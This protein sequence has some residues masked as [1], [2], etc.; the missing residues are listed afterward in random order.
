MEQENKIQEDNLQ[1]EKKLN[2]GFFIDTF[3][4]MVD[5]VIVVVDNYARILSQFANVTVF[6][7]KGRKKYDDTKLP[8][9]VVRC[10]AVRLV[11]LD[12]DLPLPKLSHKFKRELNQANLDIV[13]IHSPFTIGNLGVQYAKKHNIPVI[14]TMHSQYKKDFLKETH[15]NNWL[16]NKL[17][18]KCMKIFN[19]C[20]ECWAVND[21]VGEIYY[22]EYGAKKMPKTRF[23]GADLKPFVDEKE[24]Y[25]LKKE[26]DIHDDERV[27]LFVGRITVLKN[28]P[29]ILQSL[30]CLKDSNF[31]FKMFF[32]GAG[33]DM[34][35][36]QK[37]TNAL[38][39]DDLVRFLGRITDREEMEKMYCMADLFLF[40]SLY[41]CNSLVQIEA[42]SQS[43][44]TLFLEGAATADTVTPDKN[45]YVAENNP[46]KY[47]D[48]IIDIFKDM[49]KYNE[50]SK[51]AFSD[52]YHSWDDCVAKAWVDYNK[53]LTEKKGKHE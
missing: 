32:I 8:Y 24:I 38:K 20:D 40:P 39:I 35:K 5:G 45:G 13:H 7:V 44:P 17:L 14:G 4:P 3:F 11:G 53:I 1:V 18:A 52:L 30:K 27:L 25:R 26:Y 28:V 12:Y 2:I 46:K 48:K 22:K 36:M 23:N 50:V 43:T 51:N 19:A 16:A 21:K 29:F 47:A 10:P 6:T 34:E 9:K 41:D 31:K 33:P 15:N 42:A 49:K 37:L